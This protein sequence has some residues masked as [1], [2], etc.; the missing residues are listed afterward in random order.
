MSADKSNP[1]DSEIE[2]W[3]ANQFLLHIQKK[4]IET[5]GFESFEL[6]HHKGKL[7]SKIKKQLIDVFIIEG[8]TKQELK[9]Y[10]DWM[11]YV[12]S[13]DVKTR[14]GLGYL[15]S[16]SFMDEFFASKSK[17]EKRR[18]TSREKKLRGLL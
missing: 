11:Y 3:T 13:D 14:I 6:K 2:S 16:P 1:N 5:Y 4:F 8:K 9:D 17:N 10:I 7:W 12:K 18:M 15:C